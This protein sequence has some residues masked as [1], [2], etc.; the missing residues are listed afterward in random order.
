MAG[1]N[2]INRAAVKRRILATARAE[3][4]GWPCKRV[5]ADAYDLI[6]AKVAAYIAGLVQQHPSI[7]QTF[8]P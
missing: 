6:E 5:S 7:G 3:R 8:K 1:Q 4:P 2:L